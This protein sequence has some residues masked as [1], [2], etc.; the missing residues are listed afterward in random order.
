MT[1]SLDASG[2]ATFNLDIG[3]YGIEIRGKENGKEYFGT[4][5]MA[6]YG[7]STTVS[8]DVENLSVYGQYGRHRS[9][10]AVYNGGTYGG[11]MMHPDQYIVIANNS[12]R[13]INVSG[14]ALAQASNMNTLPCS[15]LTSLLPDYVVAANIYQIPAGQKYTLAPGEVYVIASQAQNHTE[16]YTPNPEKDTGIPVDLSGA[17]FELA[18]ND[19]AMS[20]SAVDNPKV[21]NLTKV[22]N[23]M[24]GGVTAWCILM[25]SVRCSCSTPAV[26]SGVLQEP[27][28]VYLQRPSGAAIQE[29]QG[30]KVPTNLIVDAIET[31]SATTPY[32]GNYT[33]KSLPVTV[34]KSYVQA[35][36]EGCHHNTFMYRVKGTDGKF[37]DTNDSNVDVKIEHRSDFKGYP[38]GWRNE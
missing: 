24:P 16:S 31:T 15:D 18:D 35:T 20:G 27:E 22:A 2:S 28:R 25:V 26:S 23:S 21:P 1:E 7:Q 9:F 4:T 3:S 17:D 12:D 14:L 29:Y 6:Q 19:A 30:Y 10:R 32:W 38:E 8:V 11:T 36:I 5:G 37:Q 33:S 34:D 13:E